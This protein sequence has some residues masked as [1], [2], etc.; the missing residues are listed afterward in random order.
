MAV[1]L[2]SIA[3]ALVASLLA[4][5]SHGTAGLLPAAGTALAA[6]SAAQEHASTGRN[7]ESAMMGSIGERLNA[8][9]GIPLA[10][11]IGERL[12]ALPGDPQPMCVQPKRGDGTVGCQVQK[13]S[14]YPPSVDPHTPYGRIAGYKPNDL[15]AAYAIPRGLGAGHTVAVVDAY[16]DP[17]AEADLAVYR[18]AMGLPPCTSASGCFLKTGAKAKGV[19]AGL[20]AGDGVNVA[21]AHLPP[22]DAGWSAEIA[23]DIEMVSAVCPLCRIVLVEAKSDS[24]K[25]LAGAVDVAASYRPDAISNSYYAPEHPSERGLAKHYRA[26]RTV[27]TVAAGDAGYGSTFPAASP[28]VVAVAATS[29]LPDTSSRGWT[30]GVWSGTGSGCSALMS[31]PAWQSDTGCGGRTIADVAVVGDPRTGVAIYTSI[32]P[33][34]AATGWLVAGGTS[35]GAP[36]VAALY[37][38]AGNAGSIVAPQRL[39]EQR[40]ALNPVTVGGNGTCALAYLCTA[41]AGYSGPAGNGSPRGLGAF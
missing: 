14:S 29:L 18:A 28:D 5:C 34:G 33:A 12:N 27:V 36:V 11:S 39:W 17:N 1:T 8:L 30:E 4:A 16:D 38:L 9:P 2:R 32:A 41:T 24:M 21:P 22:A 37:A 26:A 35:V 25:D 23:L 31:K 10:G 40:A 3:L 15:A 19:N 13:N 7:A 6:A 20:Q